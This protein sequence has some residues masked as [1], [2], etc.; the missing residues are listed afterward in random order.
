MHEA[1]RATYDGPGGGYESAGGIAMDA[2]GN[3]YVTGGSRS[4]GSADFVTIKYG[5]H[6]DQ[7]WLARY[8]NGAI[9]AGGGPVTV[10]VAGNVYVTGVSYGPDSEGNYP[11]DYDIITLK[12]DRD[13]NQLW[14]ARYDGEGDSVNPNSDDWAGALA[15]DAAGNVYVRGSA[16]PKNETWRSD[17]LVLKYDASGNQRWVVRY[18]GGGKDSGHALAIDA[19]GNIYVTGASESAF[20][21][22]LDYVTIK[23]NSNGNQIWLARYDGGRDYE[24][25]AIALDSDRNVY[26]TGGSIGASSSDFVT[27]KYDSNGNQ[28]WVQRYDGPEGEHEFGSAIAVGT[29][30]SVYVTGGVSGRTAAEHMATLKYDRDG[31]VLWVVEH[32]TLRGKLMA[33]GPGGDFYVT[34]TN[35]A[36]AGHA[37]RKYDSNGN[38][39]WEASANPARWTDS[40]GIIAVGPNDRVGFTGTSHRDYATMTFDAAGNS[41]WLARYDGRGGFDLAHGIAVDLA[42]NCY[43]TGTSEGAAADQ[44]VATIKY[45][46]QGR[47]IWVAHYGTSNAWN[48]AGATIAV[49]ASGCVYVA[50]DSALDGRQDY[51][52]LKYDPAGNLLWSASYDGGYF[53][54]V[55]DLKIDLAGN[56]YVT[57]SAAVGAEWWIADYATIKYDRDGNRLWVAR[58]YG[59]SAADLD[60]D[61]NGNVYVVGESALVKYD[62]NGNELWFRPF[63]LGAALAI[64]STGDI[65]VAGGGGV[66]T[67]AKYGSQGNQLWVRYSRDGYSAALALDS[68]ENVVVS[69]ESS[70]L[71]TEGH[72]Y[73]TVKYDSNGNELWFA[74]A[75]ELFGPMAV[76]CDSADNA[77]VTGDSG[78]IKY[79]TSGHQ[80]WVSSR[81]L[82]RGL[83]IDPF[84]DVYVIGQSAQNDFETTKYTLT[85]KLTIARDFSAVGITISWDT[86]AAD[87]V[88]ERSDT[89]GGSDKSWT[90]IPFP[91]Q[92][93]AGRIFIT[94]PSPAGS[95]FYRL[96]KR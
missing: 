38:W 83:A 35:L 91:Y 60:I 59:G 21:G 56:I 16:Y 27:I 89:V 70:G 29:N 15:V 11:W 62:G 94:E 10:D 2:E 82:Y 34:G 61:A 43:V 3:V 55:A 14:V 6:G 51:L 72:V 13:G 71:D 17:Y 8:N 26:V 7:L 77:Y 4:A 74:Q 90:Q 31:N 92:T 24:A 52:T 85:P 80:L 53:D 40:V 67:T 48:D 95:R 32:E 18:D 19:S 78:T 87:F 49:D 65:Y 84:G 30:G 45:D 73:R 57:G 42:G 93:N 88:L 25:A 37:F 44:S 36:A 9:G 79:D 20:T 75:D 64:N 66:I 39:L 86:P 58:F 46:L 12:Y 33:L 96:R 81:G 69:G 68:K 54:R 47:T 63:T 1:W 28:L 22:S 41:L 50:G 23:Y 76:A 5:P